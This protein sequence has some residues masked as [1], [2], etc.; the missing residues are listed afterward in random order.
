MSPGSPLRPRPLFCIIAGAHCDLQAAEESCA[1]RFTEIGQTLQLGLPPDWLGAEL[2]EDPE[3]RIAWHKFYFGLDLAFAFERTG[4]VRYPKTWIDL[5]LSFIDQVPADAETDCHVVSRRVLNWLYTW[6]RLAAIEGFPEPSGSDADR[7]FHSLETQ[8]RFIADHLTAERNH[9]TI[10]LTAVLHA[11]LAFPGMDPDDRLL[12]LAVEQLDENL[13][14]DILSDGVHVERSSHYHMM[15]VRNFLAVRANTARYGVSLPD[16]FD[17][18]LEG[19]CTFALHCHRPDGTIPA[20]SDSDSGSYLELLSL[21]GDLFDRDDLRFGGSEGSQGRPPESHQ[22]F[23]TGGYFVQRSGWG[24]PGSIDRSAR[25]LIWDCGPVGPGGHGHYDALHFE[26]SAHN[27]P[28]IADPGRYTYSEAGSEAKPNW[29]RWFKSTAAHNT[30]CVDGLDQTPYRCWDN[31]LLQEPE[32]CAELI[33][34]WSAPRLDVMG[35]TVQSPCYPARHSRWILFVDADYWLVS[36]HLESSQSHTYDLYFHLT[37]AAEGKVEISPLDD[38]WVVKSPGL[39]LAATG[40]REVKLIEGW[41]APK[42]GV[43][44]RAPIVRIRSKGPLANFHTLIV[45]L[46]PGSET[47]QLTRFEALSEKRRKDVSISWLLASGACRDR[48]SWYEGPE[49]LRSG[50]SEVPPRAEWTRLGPT[51]DV[52]AGETAGGARSTTSRP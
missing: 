40:S 43:K 28:L 42:Y 2:P 49:P 31:P 39:L 4:D 18:R 17:R 15:C 52:L 13:R 41:I 5:V 21:A 7:I 26:L 11:V 16:G 32:A 8:T 47:L 51:G 38:A 44:E 12:S 9:R 35:G 23:P 19:A 36:D 48:L 34:R 25:Y 37:P 22:N 27:R 3:W 50:E 29:R 1:G 45:P 10:E 20:I 33:G 30:V 24:K 14:Q 46:A 6:D